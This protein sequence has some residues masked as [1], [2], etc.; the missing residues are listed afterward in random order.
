MAEAE[1]TAASTDRCG[2]WRQHIADY[3][4]I[5]INGDSRMQNAGNARHS[6]DNERYKCSCYGDDGFQNFTT[7]LQ[8]QRGRA[9]P[10]LHFDARNA[11]NTGTKIQ[12]GARRTPGFITVAESRLSPE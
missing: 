12:V 10:C 11:V 2:N 6:A 4:D 7:C 8:L 1:E 9:G 3:F 5:G